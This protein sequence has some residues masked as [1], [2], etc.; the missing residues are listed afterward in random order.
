MISQMIRGTPIRRA[1]VMKFG[2]VK[3][4]PGVA[5]ERGWQEKARPL[6]KHQRSCNP[7]A[8]TLGAS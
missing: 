8:G 5:A 4:K 7:P 1:I 6:A 3:R 2:N